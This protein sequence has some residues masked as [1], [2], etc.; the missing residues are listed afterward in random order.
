MKTRSR[1]EIGEFKKR[2]AQHMANRYETH[3]QPK[4]DEIRKWICTLNEGQIATKLG[5]AS[6]TFRKYKHMYPELQKAL[7]DGTEQL[8]IELK[9]SLRTKAK[10]FYYTEEKVIEKI[11]DGVVVAKT[12]EK[13][14]KYAPPD[15]GAIH[16]LL[17]N[18]DAT[19][20]NDD[21]RTYD[22]KKRQVEVA[23]KKAEDAGW[24]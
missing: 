19:W 22:L 10:G 21:D 9:D 15:T 2:E 3:V 23:E 1:L 16:L 4:L 18:I 14:K 8:K 17:K 11:E 12:V 13:Y 20:K 24:N 7:A 5:I 6:S